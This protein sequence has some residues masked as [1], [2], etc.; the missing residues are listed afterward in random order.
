MSLCNIKPGC[1]CLQTRYP[2]LPHRWTLCLT[3]HPLHHIQTPQNIVAGAMIGISVGQMLHHSILAAEMLT[4]YTTP[5]WQS[6]VGVCLS[7]HS[8]TEHRCSSCCCSSMAATCAGS[9]GQCVES[10][11]GSVHGPESVGPLQKP[12]AGC[13]DTCDVCTASNSKTVWSV[14]TCCAGRQDKMAQRHGPTDCSCSSRCNASGVH[15]AAAS[16]AQHVS[17]AA[18]AAMQTCSRLAPEVKWVVMHV[19]LDNHVASWL[20]LQRSV[21]AY[22]PSNVVAC[23]RG[24]HGTETRIDRQQDLH[25]VLLDDEWIVL[26]EALVCL[27]DVQEQQM[28]N[29]EQQCC[30]QGCSE[31]DLGQFCGPA[32]QQD[33]V[34]LV[35]KREDALAEQ[36]LG[37]VQAVPESLHQHR[38]CPPVCTESNMAFYRL[39]QCHVCSRVSRQ[40]LLPAY[41]HMHTAHD[42]GSHPGAVGSRFHITHMVTASIACDRSDPAVNSWPIAG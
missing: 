20:P 35:K 28:P 29:V 33:P 10:L 37:G 26:E 8:S 4:D 42:V 40:K 36:C 34:R 7:V 31:A 21:T 32:K 30:W 13:V 23:G 14:S 12:S 16:R 19:C 18:A 38:P 15:Q 5:S 3:L 41:L 6:H 39:Q 27:L 9:Q 17:P 11:G 1:V 25:E 24:K 2:P 22:Q